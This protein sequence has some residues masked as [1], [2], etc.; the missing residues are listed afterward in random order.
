MKE[1][2]SVKV[3]M[4][5]VVYDAKSMGLKNSASVQIGNSANCGQSNASQ[6]KCNIGSRRQ[7]G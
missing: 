4:K 1:V 2:K 6:G 5:L 3:K 7:S